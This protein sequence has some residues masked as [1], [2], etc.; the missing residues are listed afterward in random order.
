MAF[1]FGS[2]FSVRKKLRAK[3]FTKDKRK[4]TR[5]HMTMQKEYRHVKAT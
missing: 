2:Y 1:R 5:K 4:Q 3:S